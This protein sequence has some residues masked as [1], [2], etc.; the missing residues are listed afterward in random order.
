M[1]LLVK[2]RMYVV[3]QGIYASECIAK[4]FIFGIEFV[5]AIHICMYHSSISWKEICNYHLSLHLAT[6]NGSCEPDIVTC[7]TEV[8]IVIINYYNVCIFQRT[9]IREIYH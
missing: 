8:R 9:I 6:T 1:Y 3:S 4:H 7:V 5:I 2:V